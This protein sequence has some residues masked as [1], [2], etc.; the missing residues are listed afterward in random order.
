MAIPEINKKARIGIVLL[1]AGSSSR[2]GE[3]K[4]LL[5]FD[6]QSLLQHSE[7][8]ALASQAEPVIVVLGSSADR[9]KDEVADPALT[10]VVNERWQEGM[11]SSIRCGVNKLTELAPEAQAVIIMVCDQPFVTTALLNEMITAF[12]KTGKPI[13]ACSYADTFGPPVLF[14]RSFFPELLQL[15][16][17]IGARGVIRRHVND[18]ELLPFPKGTIDV[19]T[20]A[21]YDNLKQ[22]S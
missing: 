21:D 11:A 9:L 10:I 7:Q 2:L 13:V 14:H 3:P 8:V 15:Q 17:D 19:D 20:K 16:G 12:L 22:G 4:Q 5:A 6:G 18:A 1:A